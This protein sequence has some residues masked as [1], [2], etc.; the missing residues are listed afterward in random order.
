MAT[1]TKLAFGINGHG[2]TRGI[3][4]RVAIHTTSQTV[5][6]LADTLV[7]RY[8]PLMLDHFKMIATHFLGRRHALIQFVSPG[9]TINRFTSRH[10]TNGCHQPK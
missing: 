10:A 9:R 4:A 3:L 7:Y 5:V 8:I 1:G 2:S 6:C